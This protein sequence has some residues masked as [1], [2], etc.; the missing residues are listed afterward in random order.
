MTQIMWIGINKVRTTLRNRFEVSRPGIFISLVGYD[1]WNE[2]EKYGNR[3]VNY[4]VIG[5][6]FKSLPVGMVMDKNSDKRAL[7]G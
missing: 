6:C 1:C 3:N 4:R 2:D 7:I 5:L